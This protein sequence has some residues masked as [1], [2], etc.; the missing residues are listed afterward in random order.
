MEVLMLKT[1]IHPNISRLCEVFYSKADKSICLMM[2]YYSGPTLHELM[3][4]RKSVGN[5]L[6]YYYK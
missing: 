3:N 4:Y 5:A 1:L 6:V 2:D